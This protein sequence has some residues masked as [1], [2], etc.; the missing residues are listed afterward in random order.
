MK[1]LVLTLESGEGEAFES[2]ESVKR[3][4]Y[5]CS[6]VVFSGYSNKAAHDK[7]YQHIMDHYDSY[8]I[9]IKL[10]ADM[11]F[12]TTSVVQTIVKQFRSDSNLDWLSVQV[13]DYFTDTYI[14][15]M[16]VFSN[17]CSWSISSDAV[18]VDPAP[19]F[20]GNRL[21]VATLPGAEI[22]HCK[23]PTDLQAK[24][25][26][27]HRALKVV[28]YADKVPNFGRSLVQIKTLQLVVKKYFAS[29]SKQ[30]ELAILGARTLFLDKAGTLINKSEID[31][32]L[33]D[34]SITNK[35]IQFMRFR[36]Y[37]FGQIGVRRLTLSLIFVLWRRFSY[38]RKKFF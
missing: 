34:F 15:G 20:P 3:Q 36:A 24:L 17:R 7:L 4:D 25:F 22:S 23:S 16:H 21:R 8:D 14:W 38:V 5:E 6:H 2:A 32:N 18:F 13:F 19:K 29:H 27:Y 37:Y 11:V 9:F 26:G 28:Q 1:V 12:E 35:Q 33:F 30:C 10:D 31:D